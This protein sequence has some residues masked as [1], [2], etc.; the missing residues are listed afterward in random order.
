MPPSSRK[1]SKGKER[2]AKQQ[3]KK[4]ENDR[5]DANRFWRIRL[6]NISIGCIHGCDVALSNDHPVS[7]FMDQFCIKLLHNGMAASDNLRDTYETHEVV[8]NNES[9]RKTVLDILIRIGTN[10]LLREECDMIWPLFIAQSIMV[11][12][13]YNG[14]DDV[15]SVINK[16]VVVS[17]W[18]ELNITGSSRRD[19][20]KFFRKRISCKCLKKLHLEARKNEPKMGI[21]EHCDEE[22]ERTLLDLCSRCNIC[23]YCSRECQVAD[24]PRH[25]EEC[26]LFVGAREKETEEQND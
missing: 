7:S 2:K 14:T 22:K 1:R 15:D 3:A 16:P 26:N 8:W 10:A 21:C 23:H 24:W 18:R 13:H 11:L 9:Y 5:A 12:E 17:K 19:C 20:L 4:V 6:C 25:K